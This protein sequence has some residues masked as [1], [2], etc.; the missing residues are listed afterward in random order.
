MPVAAGVPV[1][2][3]CGGP[4]V[5]KMRSGGW[6]GGGP[7]GD[8]VLSRWRWAAVVGRGVVL[9]VAAAPFRLAAGGGGRPAWAPSGAVMGRAGHSCCSRMLRGCWPRWGDGAVLLPPN[10]EVRLSISPAL[11]NKKD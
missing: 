7:D 8:G 4:W 9:Q 2:L 11:L 6:T 3:S 1:L 10:E 5:L